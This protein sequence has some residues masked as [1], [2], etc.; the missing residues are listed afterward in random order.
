MNDRDRQY[1]ILIRPLTAEEVCDRTDKGEKPFTTIVSLDMQ[2]IACSSDNGS[3]DGLNELVDRERAIAEKEE[4]AR[5]AEN[6]R[7]EEVIADVV[8][9]R[10]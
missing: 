4:A 9:R 6:A 5:V 2:E 8:R 3:L 7:L 10:A 1:S